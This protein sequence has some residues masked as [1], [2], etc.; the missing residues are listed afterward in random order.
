MSY[1]VISQYAILLVLCSVMSCHVISYVYHIMLCLI[2]CFV[3]SCH[4]MP[5]NDV[6]WHIAY[7]GVAGIA[8]NTTAL[9]LLKS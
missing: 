3:M 2:F 6:L 7:N 5:S 1:C 9:K 8:G 4:I